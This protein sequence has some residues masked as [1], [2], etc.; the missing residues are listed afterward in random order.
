M[1]WLLSNGAV[2]ALVDLLDHEDRLVL[3]SVVA[4]VW[5]ILDA[6]CTASRLTI[7]HKTPILARLVALVRH[8]TSSIGLPSVRAL[9]MLTLLPAAASYCAQPT[10]CRTVLEVLQCPDEERQYHAAVVLLNVCAGD[11]ALHLLLLDDPA[12]LRALVCMLSSNRCTHQVCCELLLAV[13]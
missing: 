12:P 4:S 10:L 7:V 1:D 13:R 11:D 9:A 5:T 2:S 6:A 8:K 3:E